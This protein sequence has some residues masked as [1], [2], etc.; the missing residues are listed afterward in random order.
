[1]TRSKTFT[2]GL[3]ALALAGTACKKT[4][5][6]GSL[7]EALSAAKG[8]ADQA[9]TKVESAVGSGAPTAQALAPKTTRGFAAAPLGPPDAIEPPERTVLPGMTIAEARAAGATTVAD[10]DTELKVRPDVSATID[11][12]TGFVEDLQV[13]LPPAAWATQQKAWGAPAIADED[14]WIGRNWMARLNGCA[15]GPCWLTFTRSPMSQFTGDVAPPGSLATLTAGMTLP[16]VVAA[17]GIGFTGDEPILLGYGAQVAL[18]LD[19]ELLESVHLDIGAGTS[20]HWLGTFTKLWGAPKQLGDDK[21][22][23]A[24]GGQWMAAFDRYGDTL[25]FLPLVRVSDAL[26]K[27]ARASVLGQAKAALGKPLAGLA[28]VPGWSTDGEDFASYYTQLST[29]QVVIGAEDDGTVVTEL[30]AT[31]PVGGDAEMATLTAALTTGLGPITVSK[32]EDGE[33]LR[34]IVVDGIKVK[35]ESGAGELTLTFTK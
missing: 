31:F 5:P 18:G 34:Q 32:D 6:K 15:N 26:G 17:S 11:P 35:V 28:S 3:A 29:S 30:G 8:A 16:Q 24:K 10:H 14:V 22:W 25:E 12:D 33:E 13:E 7:G 27:T 21:V 23:I 1:M 19:D 20:D 2:I 4:E 9:A